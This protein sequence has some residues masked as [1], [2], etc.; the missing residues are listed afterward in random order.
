MAATTGVSGNDIERIS[1]L[2]SPEDQKDVPINRV[3][4]ALANLDQKPVEPTPATPA[5]KTTTTTP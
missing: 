2:I 5:P 4:T 3:N 1:G